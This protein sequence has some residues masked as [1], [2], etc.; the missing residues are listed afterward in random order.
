MNKRLLKLTY[1][2]VNIFISCLS[3]NVYANNSQCKMLFQRPRGITDVAANWLS[4]HSYIE[5][6]QRKEVLGQVGTFFSR[7]WDTQIYY[8]KTAQP[9]IKGEVPLVD[10]E[11]KAVFIFFHGSG[12]QKSGGQNF[13]G[14]MNTLANMGYSAISFD[15]PFHSEGPRSD[16]FN[17]SN[18]F[19]E[20]A[21]SIILEAK[22][23]GKPVYLAGHSFGPDAILELVTRYPK[24]V[25]GVAALSP[26]GFTKELSHWYDNYTTK[27]KFGGEVESN[28]DGG[29][30]AGGMS[31][32]FL[33]HKSKLPDPTIV[34][35]DLKIRIFSGNREEYVPAPIGGENK[36]P[37]GENTYDIRIPLKNI[38]KNAVVTIEPGIG[39]YIFDFQDSNG[40]NVVTRELLLVAGESPKNI[41]ELIK[42][43]RQKNSLLDK[44]S[45]LGKKYAQDQ[46]FKSWADRTYGKGKALVVSKNS[47]DGLAEKM[48]EEFNLADEKRA[49]EIYQKILNSKTDSPEFYEKYKE[50]IDKANPKK[51]EKSLFIPYLN[52]VLK[53]KK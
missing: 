46:L 22:K 32:Q 21:R 38:F 25:D 6:T 24:M 8:T 1:I 51:T 42:S 53:N 41:D 11:S 7:K 14:N 15:M 45:I 34:N 49:S 5:T 29:Y 43:Q 52:F 19:M 39:H 12:T 2:S 33:W 20:W 17:K 30:W 16:T 13:M 18:Y 44:S 37:I 48:L 26:A 4:D 10:P 28:D 31:N 50:L 9:D 36:T 23:S 47:Q 40:V 3:L 27:M 35:P